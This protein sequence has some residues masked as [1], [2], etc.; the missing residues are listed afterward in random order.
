MKFEDIKTIGVMGGGV[1][2][3]GIAQ[4]MAAA[5]YRVIVR[6]LND[7]LIEK[8]RE[9]IFESRWG[10]KRAVEIGKLEFDKARATMERISFTTKVEDLR[11]VDMV[12]E[13]VPEKLELK[14]QVFAELD[15]IV[16]PDT[17]FVSNTS[18]F[19]VAE[20]AR[21]VSE[22]RKALFAGM[23]FFNPV[24]AMKCVEIISTPQTLPEVTDAV[25]RVGEQAGKVAVHVKDAPGTYG[26]IVNRVYAAARRE[27]DKLVE[28]GIATKEDIDKAMKTGRN[29]PSGF[30][31]ER[32]GIGRQW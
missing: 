22:G 12:I 18:G 16:K 20:M 8:T 4:V 11:N 13:A 14:Q 17:I 25:F 23:H 32:G 27:A 1:M 15:K 5:G 24:P 6:D 9:A 7:D 19:V 21:D 10:I 31:E 3:G 2:G 26:F 30:Y 28:A 29:W